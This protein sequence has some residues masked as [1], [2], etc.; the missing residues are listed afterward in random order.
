MLRKRLWNVAMLCCLAMFL[1][2]SGALMVNSFGKSAV[3]AEPVNYNKA[4]NVVDSV[5]DFTFTNTA[6]FASRWGNA[7]A[8]LVIDNANRTMSV[9]AGQNIDGVIEM[10]SYHT[11]FDIKFGEGTYFSI[12]LRQNSGSRTR[13]G[14]NYFGSLIDQGDDCGY[15]LFI[16]NQW[17]Q[18]METKGGNNNAIANTAPFDSINPIGADKFY[19]FEI[20]VLNL[21]DGS[22]Q[23]ILDVDGVNYI[24]KNTS[25]V[26]NSLFEKPITTGAM[27]LFGGGVSAEVKGYASATDARYDLFSKKNF[28]NWTGNDQAAHAPIAWTE[29]GYEIGSFDTLAGWPGAR[30]TALLSN[31]EVGSFTSVFTFK[32][33]TAS[34][35]SVAY[36]L[37]L[38]YLQPSVKP[39]AWIPS[40]NTFLMQEGWV[41]GYAIWINPTGGIEFYKGH[42]DGTQKMMVWEGSPFISIADGNEHT[43]Y[44][45]VKQSADRSSQIVVL[46][47]DGKNII[48]YHSQVTVSRF[49][50]SVTDL[51]EEEKAKWLG[52]C[53]VGSFQIMTNNISGTFTNVGTEEQKGDEFKTAE[54]ITLSGDVK[55]EYI[56]GDELDITG[57]KARVFYKDSTYADMDVTA[58]MVSGFNS[59]VANKNLPITVTIA[60][61]TATYNVSV[62]YV[63]VNDIVDSVYDFTFTNTA[64][65]ASRWGNQPATV[66][67]NNTA[68]TMSVMNEQN[69]D[70]VMEMGSYHTKFDVKF[71]AGTAFSIYL[72]QNSGSRTKAGGSYFSTYLDQGED[73]GYRLFI[74]NQC[75]QFMET[76]GGNNNAI[77]NT[78][79][80]DSIN[81]IG[82]DK[83]Y[84]F[85]IWV[86]NLVD[87]SVQFIVDV[88]GVNYINKNTS[89]IQNSLFE[90]PITKGAMR[91]YGW[92]VS[93]EFKGYASA[94]DAR[95]DLFKNEN[96]NNWTGNEGGAPANAPMTWTENGYEIGAFDTV[97]G[98]PDNLTKATALIGSEEV[99]SFS[100]VFTFKG[101]KLGDDNDASNPYNMLLA[102]VEPGVKGDAWMGDV[103][104]QLM[105]ESGWVNGYVLW[106]N[107]NGA[108]EL[109]K[110]LNT[111]EARQMRWLPAN[112][113]FT[114]GNEHTF[115]FSVKQSP[116]R[117]YQ[118]VTLD[119][120]GVNI[121]DYHSNMPN[122]IA[123]ASVTDLSAED[124]AKW[125]TSCKVGSLQ[126][127]TQNISGVF[128]NVGTEEQ[129]GTEFKTAERLVIL[130]EPK[131]HYAVGD[132]LDVNGL[133][134]RVIYADGTYKDVAVTADMV[135]GFN[136]EVENENLALTITCE[137]V[138]YTYNVSVELGDKATYTVKE[139]YKATYQVG[140]EYANDIVI[141]K[142]LLGVK[143]EFAVTADMISGF[144]TTTGG[145]VEL[146]I[147]VDGTVV[148]VTVMVEKVLV[149]ISIADGYKVEY[150]IG[151]AFDYEDLKGKLALSYNDGTEEFIDITANMLSQRGAFAGENE[152]T[153]TYGAFEATMTVKGVGANAWDTAED[154]QIRA[155]LPEINIADSTVM[156]GDSFTQ[157]KGDTVAFGK[158]GG[159]FITY[160]SN[161]KYAGYRMT[162]R[163][164]IDP[165]AADANQRILLRAS[166]ADNDLM[167]GYFIL[168]YKTN[169][170]LFRKPVNSSATYGYMVN[171]KAYTVEEVGSENI[172]D[173]K[174][175]TFVIEVFNRSEEEVVFN[176]SI[177][178]V[179]VMHFVDNSE[180][181]QEVWSGNVIPEA[182]CRVFAE[183]GYVGFT[184]NSAVSW[185]LKGEYSD[186]AFAPDVYLG[187]PDIYGGVTTA[188]VENG[189]L[190]F[191]DGDIAVVSEEKESFNASFKL[192]FN[193]VS[194]DEMFVVS[195]FTTRVNSVDYEKINGVKFVVY[196]DR[197]EIVFGGK[198]LVVLGGLTLGEG[199]EI[200]VKTCVNFIGGEVIFSMSVD[201]EW[202]SASVASSSVETTG[203][204]SAFA[205]VSTE[206]TA[207]A[208]E[209]KNYRVLFVGNSITNHGANTDIGYTLGSATDTW[210]MATS[211]PEFDYVHLVM[212][213]IR[214]V[215]GYENA[216]F[217]AIN[218]ANWERAYASYD[219]TK[220]FA[221]G[222]AFGADLI[223]GRIS[224]NANSCAASYKN[225]NDF[226][227]Y[228]DELLRFF[229]SKGTAQIVLT[230]SYWGE[231]NYDRDN[232]IDE[233]I[234]ELAKAKNYPLVRLG[235]LGSRYNT[236]ND[237]SADGEYYK[238]LEG[239]SPGGYTWEEEWNN[240]S[241]DVKNHPG[242]NGMKN[243]A[244][245]IAESVVNLLTGGDAFITKYEELAEGI[246]A[247]YT[248][249]EL[250]G[251]V[252]GAYDYA[253]IT[254]ISL[255][256]LDNANGYE[257]AE[258]YMLYKAYGL[259]A[260]GDIYRLA[261][262]LYADVNAS[263]NFKVYTVINGELKEMAFY[264]NT[265]SNPEPTISVSGEF[266]EKIF[267]CIEYSAEKIFADA[268]FADA[269]YGNLVKWYSE[270]NDELVLDVS[271]LGYDNLTLNTDVYSVIVSAGKDLCIKFANGEIKVT[272]QTFEVISATEENLYFAVEQLKTANYL[273]NA[274]A[275]ITAL[276][277]EYAAI[278][279]NESGYANEVYEPQISY[280]G[281]SGDAL[282]INKGVKVFIP[283]TLTEVQA[284]KLVVIT[285]VLPVLGSEVKYVEILSDNL[286]SYEN[287]I[288]TLT[289]KDFNSDVI[290][291]FEKANKVIAMVDG[292]K[293]E[294]TVGEQLDLTDMAVNYTDEYGVTTQVAV[295]A[296]MVSGFDTTKEGECTVTVTY[297]GV[298]CEFT[299][300]VVKGEETSSGTSDS[301]SI[302]TSDSASTDKTNNCFAG[303]MG[304]DLLSILVIAAIAIKRKSK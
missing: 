14:G 189:K 247:E 164:K 46:D 69:I 32:G 300:N 183:T 240:W 49:G 216:E 33:N 84:T 286:W 81:P 239:T 60:G 184:M 204:V 182:D 115:Y 179:N 237:A 225:D 45:S 238:N 266:G 13:A 187:N 86:L 230:T 303:I 42:N 61:A 91:L 163:S 278:S 113:N 57:L 193:Q 172:Y 281:R 90:K 125:L 284:Q 5:Y 220:D 21:A 119:I 116:D 136:S 195:A 114:D 132:E 293:T 168:L 75:L 36:N 206:L 102:Y 234:I 16:Q 52:S 66:T 35:A 131:T 258:N 251:E 167:N 155:T 31:E 231:E 201:G 138:T 246:F 67:I 200:D 145:E 39:I 40:Q 186:S 243:I 133:T 34:E 185:M 106:I 124:Q 43:I 287:G 151:S 301:T 85:E 211:S 283:V 79:P 20:W 249:S 190:T 208:K 221:E 74:Q 24:N 73:S 146:T 219:Y 156:S 64:A 98:W 87:G 27:R 235:D 267:F 28:N 177:D 202:I 174:Y 107:S 227:H 254:S 180:V 257:F 158:S 199:S 192:K 276:G 108:I 223:I 128:T 44:F 58:D 279:T 241:S 55:T 105:C 23:F 18:F 188:I 51:T 143:T 82:A 96:F 10:G 160:A 144:D 56:I 250:Y 209:Q 152:I 229:N 104:S 97:D 76:K 285:A 270:Q 25:E 11:K 170:Q 110:G 78:A 252:A 41:N 80:F 274:T 265:E 94:T 129:K 256:E 37:S 228:Y 70:G 176:M 48:T 173:N 93:A 191:T 71:S 149:G 165:S 12:F 15:R 17:I 171:A 275:T 282:Y 130:G 290:L 127:I 157:V 118:I 304:V 68:R 244:A 298:T 259:Q 269:K 169:W 88:D 137:G 261:M 100:S 4:E 277:E 140:E 295:T 297:E 103:N 154:K 139:G 117:S 197:A 262:K 141:V 212:K 255:T 217:M 134:A 72:K 232:I 273:K 153:V 226:S 181:T 29:N 299:I 121:V 264:T 178:G 126:I 162:F 207:Q 109:L 242:M 166:V 1:A 19:T 9:P 233:Q 215:E 218:V 122:H 26:E 194:A 142:T 302:G 236:V 291:A 83:F 260:D 147:S 296:E 62:D 7:G 38:A 89:E 263:F 294:Y 112:V 248:S 198:T 120:D 289:I 288:L 92:G 99:G 54:R 30:E 159:G 175:H 292:Y 272:A 47:I 205:F 123:G 196:V 222:A 148:A 268:I 280:N 53:S 111:G 271:A 135:S 77:A 8:G 65:F 22:V 210:G 50:A 214:E 161:A 3:S 213:A 224:E 59:T 63:D 6:T 101:A 203:Y 95:F 253:K 2:V 245:R 150:T